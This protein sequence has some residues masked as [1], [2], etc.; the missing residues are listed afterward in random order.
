[1]FKNSTASELIHTG[2][3]VLLGYHLNSGST[4][5]VLLNDGIGATPA[6]A[7]KATQTLTNATSFSDGET[8]TIGDGSFRIVYTMKTSL[9]TGFGE[10][11][12]EILIGAN[13]A[14][15][16]DNI[17]SAINDSGTEGTEY[18]NGTTA[19]LQVTA[20]TNGAT[21]QVIEARQIGTAGNAI[22]CTETGA[23]SA[24][25]AATLTGG[26][27]AIILM[28]NTFVPTV[29]EH[30]LEIPFVNGLYWVEGGT[31]DITFYWKN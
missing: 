18:S 11:A 4:P 8:I 17:K 21:T 15:S 19:H 23:T 22:T 31:V 6:A 10:R 28:L 27:Q 12:N 20:T 13:V 16:L 30:P 26:L 9:S 1:M 14:A 5:T 2:S 7:V 29:G 3:G 25:G 24:W